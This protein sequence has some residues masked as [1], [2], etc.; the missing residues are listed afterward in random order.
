MKS[1][2]T[3]LLFSLFLT[4]CHSNAKQPN[5]SILDY[6]WIKS[7]NH[8][9]F[10]SKI[11]S[12]TAPHSIFLET[13]RENKGVLGF[14]VPLFQNRNSRTEVSI[15]INYKIE[16]GSELLLKLITIGDCEKVK[17][18]DTLYLS[19]NEEWTTA[20]LSV[21][22]MKAAFLNL[23][24][25]VKG[26]TENN[27]KLWINDLGVFRNGKNIGVPEA[28]GKGFKTSLRKKDIT[29]FDNKIRNNLP[30]MD[31]EILA[32][33]ETIHGTETMNDMGIKIIKDRITYNN[34]KLALLEIPFENSFYINRYICGDP[35]FKIDSISNY[36]DRSLFSNSF[37]SLIE[38]I[39]KHN[40]LSEEKVYFWG[41]DVNHIQLQS[42]LELFNFF[43][44]L[45]ETAR[46][47]ELNKVCELLVST[48][49]SLD[50]VISIFD[51]NKG[52]KSILTED[53]SKLMGV[54]HKLCK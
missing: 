4:Q 42:K 30:F 32:I 14:S 29:F 6:N 5:N 44:T 34:C 28:A 53:E 48:S 16:N 25:E 17:S 9:F 24:I 10:K 26:N 31:R 20:N 51:A 18:I 38:W 33:G 19:L 21:D 43:Y 45:N 7:K 52:F 46:D 54:S 39:K 27:A 1:F 47:E 3:L 49:P 37:L 35:N 12:T 15:K 8:S 23:S 40:S 36:F 11:D 41:I 50:E 13:A 2:F 22:L